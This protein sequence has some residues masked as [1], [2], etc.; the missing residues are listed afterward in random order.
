MDRLLPPPHKCGERKPWCRCLF[1]AE[2][3]NVGIIGA[4]LVSISKPRCRLLAH[5]CLRVLGRACPL[6][7]GIS[8]VDLFSYREGILDLDAEVSDGAFDFGVAKQE[9]HGAQVA[10]STIDQRRLCSPQ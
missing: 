8:D 2:L 5:R 10:G 3:I 7:P 9:L 1:P 6:C 4:S